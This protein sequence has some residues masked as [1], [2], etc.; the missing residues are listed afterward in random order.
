MKFEV[1]YSRSLTQS[2]SARTCLPDVVR[3]FDSEAAARNDVPPKGA[4]IALIRQIE[5]SLRFVARVRI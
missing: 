3:E 4:K 1:R 2:Q 5:P